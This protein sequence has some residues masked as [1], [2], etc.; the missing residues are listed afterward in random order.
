MRTSPADVV[1]RPPVVLTA[2][3][4]TAGYGKVQIIRDVSVDIGRGE[5]V[6]IVG[7]NGAGK[8]TLLKAIMGLIHVWEGELTVG[9]TAAGALATDE[10]VRRGVGYV[11]QIGDVFT[12]LS[13]SENL[14][15]GAYTLPK[16]EVS[17]RRQEVIDVFPRVG[18][19]L[20]RTAGK[21]SGGERK[22]VGIA[23]ALMIRPSVLLLDEPTA[24]LS[25]EVANTLLTTHLEAMRR[26][27]VGVLLV[28]QKATAAL[29][30]ADWSYVMA[31]GRVGFSARARELREHPRFS[32]IFFGVI[33]PGA[34]ATPVA[35]DITE[36]TSVTTEGTT[37]WA[38]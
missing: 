17:K 29:D 5:V 16:A 36:T 13:V 27:G 23:R 7:P 14:D 9:D 12:P 35:V 20:D 18:T 4:F 11:P 6:A 1:P 10:L 15:I 30:A 37:A 33:Q 19:L 21:L 28:E 25:A 2:R 26:L 31:S 38:K 8:S 34:E 22:M 24:G 3:G 32:D